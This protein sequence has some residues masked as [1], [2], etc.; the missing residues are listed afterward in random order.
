MVTEH[1]RGVRLPPGEDVSAQMEWL[2]RASTTPLVWTTPPSR[3]SARRRSSA[4]RGRVRGRPGT[5]KDP[6][7]EEQAAAKKVRLK[8]YS[9]KVYKRVL[10]KPVTQER[11]G[12]VQANGFRGHGFGFSRPPVRVQ[13]KE[14]EWKGKLDEAKA[15]GTRRDQEANDMVTLSTRCSSRTS[16]S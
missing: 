8:M 10:D 11:G 16:V 13:G 4:A 1:L 15:L 5:K 9:Q 12:R 14:Q 6:S 7:H 3:R 2:W